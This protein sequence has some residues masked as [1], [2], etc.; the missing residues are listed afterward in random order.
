M[1]DTIQPPVEPPSLELQMIA[2]LRCRYVQSV[3]GNTE[4]TDCMPTWVPSVIRVE[5]PVHGT[6]PDKESSI[7]FAGDYACTTTVF[8]VIKA[9]A[10]DGTMITVSPLECEI[11][12]FRWNAKRET[13]LREQAEKLTTEAEP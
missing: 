9:V 11:L 1:T 2:Y 7:V 6:W 4:S 8:G 5:R 13:V 10:D 3:L 12:A